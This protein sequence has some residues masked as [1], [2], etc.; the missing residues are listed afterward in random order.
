[1]HTYAHTLTHRHTQTHTHTH[2]Y[3]H[4]H[5]GKKRNWRT[6]TDVVSATP[7][8]WSWTNCATVFSGK[9]SMATSYG[10]RRSRGCQKARV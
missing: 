6:R 3:T 10:V 7:L 1:M 4:V 2:T 5:K 9:P 8:K